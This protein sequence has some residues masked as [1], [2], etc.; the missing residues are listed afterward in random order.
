MRKRVSVLGLL[1]ATAVVLMVSVIVLSAIEVATVYRV[2][3]GRGSAHAADFIRDGVT[4]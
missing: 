1:E 4:P 3:S 2:V